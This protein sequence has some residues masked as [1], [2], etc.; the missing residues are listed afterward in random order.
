MGFHDL[1][2]YEFICG[3]APLGDKD[4]SEPWSKR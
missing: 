4:Q 2:K 3:Y 1:K